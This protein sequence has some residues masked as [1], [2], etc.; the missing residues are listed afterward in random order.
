MLSSDLYRAARSESSDLAE[1]VKVLESEFFGEAARAIP[2]SSRSAATV[3][4]ERAKGDPKMESAVEI[5]VLGAREKSLLL[6]GARRMERME[7]LE[8]ERK[9][10][11]SAQRYTLLAASLLFVPFILAATVSISRQLGGALPSES[12]LFYV[13]VQAAVSSFALETRAK[14]LFPLLSIAV[15]KLTEVIM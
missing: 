5:L 7:R 9:S 12:I 13:A 14:A 4:R 1:I 8:R 11:T 6:D 10:A 3:L 15:Y 2:R